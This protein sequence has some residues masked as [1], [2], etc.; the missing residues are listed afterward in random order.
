MNNCPGFGY[1]SGR[2]CRGDRA[3]DHMVKELTDVYKKLQR[4]SFLLGSTRSLSSV[5]NVSHMHVVKCANDEVYMF[6]HSFCIYSEKRESGEKNPHAL[7]FFSFFF[8]FAWKDCK[9]SIVS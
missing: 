9:E 7:F 8:F 6:D 2:E 4:V 5:L 3:T 1:V